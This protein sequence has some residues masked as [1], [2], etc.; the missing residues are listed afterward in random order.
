MRIFISIIFFFISFS[1]TAQV[2]I[3]ETPSDTYFFSPERD[4]ITGNFPQII[5]VKRVK[6]GLFS[7]TYV[8]EHITYR[9]PKR[10][11]WFKMIANRT[12]QTLRVTPEGFEKI[13]G[14]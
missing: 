8:T 9:I 1:A 10:R 4:E 3:K 6:N 13:R 14:Y 11:S 7:V 2:V 12:G 5:P